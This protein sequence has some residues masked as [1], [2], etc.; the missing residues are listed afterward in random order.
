MIFKNKSTNWSSLFFSN[1]IT[2]GPTAFLKDPY[3]LKFILVGA[4]IYFKQ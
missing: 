1:R 2:K 3:A 4:L